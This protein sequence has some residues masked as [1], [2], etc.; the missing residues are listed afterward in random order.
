MSK[1]TGIPQLDAVIAATSKKFERD[2]GHEDFGDIKTFSSGSLQLDIALKAGG[3]PEGRVIEVY[4]PTSSMKTSFCLQAVGTKQRAR[5]LAG[6]QDKRDLILDLE[7]SLTSSFLEGFGFDLD[8]QT[9]WVRPRSAEEA[10]QISIDYVKS[11]AIDCVV[12][13][14][15][16]AAQNEKQ[17]RRSIGEADVGGIS[18][19]M[20]TAMRQISKIGPEYNTTYFFINQVRQNPGVMF[21]N[22]EVTPGGN[23]LAFYATLRLRFNTRKPCPEI[24]NASYLRA[25]IIKT[26]IGEE[27]LEEI[28]MPFISGK[29]FATALDIEAVAKELGIL[30]H[31]AGQSKI[32]WI[33][34]GAFEPLLPDIEKGKEAGQQALITNPL[35]VEKIRQA[36]F[37]H[38]NVS[39]KLTPEQVLALRV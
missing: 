23:A 16:D 31:S 1:K 34:D 30:K 29:G 22:P 26:K 19:D 18:K 38:T 13:D 32:Q 25:K 20:S 7:H 39:C 21:G 35:L 27:Y 37:L 28:A 11:G 3:L 14:S 5:V 12:F 24:P 36:C 8:E 4:G 17:Q 2:L 33:P 15:V 10:L 6:V 9:I